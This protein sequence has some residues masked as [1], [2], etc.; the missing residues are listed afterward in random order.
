MLRV[1]G[2]LLRPSGY[3]GQAGFWILGSGFIVKIGRG[4]KAKGKRPGC[5]QAEKPGSI[6][7]GFRLFFA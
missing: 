7:K 5:W 4:I 3:A 6:Q 1:L 2:S